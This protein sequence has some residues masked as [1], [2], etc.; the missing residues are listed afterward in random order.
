MK[1]QKPIY[2]LGSG[3]IGLALA[4]NLIQNN[5]EV[6]LVK[7]SRD[8]F[9]EEKKQISMEVING[10][11]STTSISMVSLS[12]IESL[13][14]IIVITAKS[15]A[16]ETIASKLREKK[17][18]SPLVVMQNG[19]GVEKPF[20]GKGFAEIYRCILFVTSQTISEY[21]VRYRPIKP[22]PIGIIKGNKQ[23]LQGIVNTLNCSN[24]SFYLEDQ[25]QEKIWQKAIINSVF[26][27]ICP[28][29]NIDNGI[30]FRNKEVTHIAAEIIKETNVV[31]AAEGIIL[32]EEEILQQVL[33]ISEISSGQ[34]I[35]TL[36]DLNNKRKTEI[37]FFC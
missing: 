25:I 21:Y 1:A 23:N 9:L 29:L 12:R 22:S 4:V 19:L 33:N 7:I 35:S 30:F 17:V 6:I 20:I 32:D 15:H 24:F 2:I 31:A 27:S 16:N 36:Q 37:D 26:N 13:S 18:N 5:N 8:D 14:G 10:Q 11:K 28:L 3:A 34:L